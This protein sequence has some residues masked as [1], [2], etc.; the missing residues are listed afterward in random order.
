[1]DLPKDPPVHRPRGR[2][3]AFAAKTEQN[4]I[5]ALDRAMRVLETLARL[6][7]ATLTALAQATGDAPATVYRILITLQA[8]DIVEADEARQTWHVGPGAFL[9]GSGFLRRTSVVERSRPVLR[10]LM[11]DSGETANLGIASDDRVLFVS[12]V[13][14][15]APIRAFFP[16]GTRSDLHAS[17]IGKVLLAHMPAPSRARIL[18][19]GLAGYTDR[20]LTDPTALERELERI[21]DEGHAIDDEERNL[22][23]RCIAAPVRNAYG[24]TVAG[25]SVSGPTSRVGR[26]KVPALADLVMEAG[27]AISAGLGAPPIP[28]PDA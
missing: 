26:D 21:R 1:M 17:G 16:P 25:L 8:R 14:T 18:A 3:R 24:E 4:T 2:P 23:M 9:I 11:E 5:Q 6:H 10:R 28:R 13:E 27:R 12:Q 20:T 22:G 15:H 19:A 7:E